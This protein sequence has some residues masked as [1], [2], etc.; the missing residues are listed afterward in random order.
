MDIKT[1]KNIATLARIE[2][3]EKEEDMM[4]KELS[5]V[6]DYVKQ[7]EEVN[8]E[9]IEPLYQ[10]TGLVNSVRQDETMGSFEMNEQLNEKLIGQAPDKEKRFIKV[11]SV[12]SK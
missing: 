4:K 7:L 1:I 10:T 2:L 3:G 12:L 5:S 11:K 6:L 8:T 9:N